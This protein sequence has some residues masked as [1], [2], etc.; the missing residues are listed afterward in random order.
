MINFA[1]ILFFSGVIFIAS[2]AVIFLFAKIGIPIGRLPGDI[3]IE[4]ENV[5]CLIALGT[6]ILLSIGLTLL[7]NLFTRFWR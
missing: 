4:T 3:K 1:R 2:S 6:S 7:L 5:T